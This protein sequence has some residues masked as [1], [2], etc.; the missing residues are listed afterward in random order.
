[1][2]TDGVMS[3][4]RAL[5]VRTLARQRELKQ[6]ELLDLKNT[7]QCKRG[8]FCAVKQAEL[9]FEMLQGHDHEL[10]Y[11]IPQQRQTCVFLVGT[12]PVKITQTRGDINGTIRCSCTMSECMY[13]ML[14]TLCGLHDSIPFN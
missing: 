4:Q 13:T 3:E 11:R 9:S 6:R 14:K 5:A 10:Q 12:S 1:M 2:E 7:H 8:I